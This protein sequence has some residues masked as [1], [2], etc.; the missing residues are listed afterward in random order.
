MDLLRQYVYHEPVH[1][2]PK[3]IRLIHLDEDP[4]QLGKN[5]VVEVGL[6]GDTQ[7]GLAELSTELLAVMNPARLE[8]AKHRFARLARA[9]DKTR[10]ALQERIEAQR[11]QRP[12]TPLCLMGAIARVLPDDIAV[13]EEAVTT[14]NTTLERL[15]ALRNT[16][17]YFGHRGWALGWGLGC[18]L[19]V[20]LAWPARPVLG[21]LGEGSALYGIQGLWS[22]CNNAQ[23][24]IL[25]IGAQGLQ[26]PR[27]QA[28]RY[29]GLDLVDP[30]VDMVALAQSLG[31]KAVRI[32][33]PDALSDALQE[34]F[35]Q[36]SPLL[37]DVPM[38]RQ[39]PP[40]LDYG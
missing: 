38:C 6:I 14:T 37:I 28:G 20:Q 36:D 16:T 17:G 23:Y 39:T 40:R 1:A 31:V 2:I 18:T 26:L 8:A 5:Y 7:A 11:S 32:S 35:R 19:G 24:Q 9:H 10:R 15:G 12:M 21:L 30:E 13:I 3:H 25:K 27:A 34:A 29:E 22:I 33:E 4:W